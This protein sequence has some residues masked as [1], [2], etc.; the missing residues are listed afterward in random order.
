[1]SDA[2]ELEREAEAARARLSDTAEQIRARMSPGQM[3]DEVLN[4]VRGGD[5][6]QMLANLRDQAKNNPM[7][8]ALV[9]SGL[10]WLMMGTGGQTPAK[11][12]GCAL[13]RRGDE[14]FRRPPA[15][16]CVPPGRGGRYLRR[17]PA[18][19]HSGLRVPRPTAKAGRS[20]GWRRPRRTALPT[21]FP[22]RAPP[23]ARGCGRPATARTS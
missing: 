21:P 11:A 5:G 8:L 10:A 20:Q 7:A 1:M 16:V 13:R 22:R 15:G 9:G 19:G 6:S 14:Q 4:Q 3:M 23:W 17:L 2:A 12:E 18:G